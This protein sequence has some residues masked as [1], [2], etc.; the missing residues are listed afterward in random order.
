MNVGFLLRDCF[1][2]LP[3]KYSD[4]DGLVTEL[5]NL[6]VFEVIHYV[7]KKNKIIYVR[8][9]NTVDI[10]R[11]D[12]RKET[13]SWWCSRLFGRPVGNSDLELEI[14]S[15]ILLRYDSYDVIYLKL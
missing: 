15:F 3:Q 2:K 4:S 1:F 13:K 7:C 14:F 5:L 6:H 12:T 11:Q 10:F 8:F 9:S